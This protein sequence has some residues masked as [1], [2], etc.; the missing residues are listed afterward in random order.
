MMR[1]SCRADKKDHATDFLDTIYTNTRSILRYTDLTETGERKG[2]AMDVFDSGAVLFASEEEGESL[3]VECAMTEDGRL[4][5][6]QASAGP[7]TK[8]SFRESPHTVEAIADPS[9]VEGLLEYF[10]L[11]AP[12]QLPAVLRLEYTG[13]DCFSDLCGLMRRLGISYEIKEAPIAR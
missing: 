10:H 12:H 8:W 7:L 2:T 3:T 4:R 11:D 5:I 9:G 13:Y 6:V 1:L